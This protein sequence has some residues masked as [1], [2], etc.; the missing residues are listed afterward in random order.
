MV[1]LNS[2]NSY[3]GAIC[4]CSDSDDDGRVVRAKLLVSRLNP[5]RKVQW[6]GKGKYGESKSKEVLYSITSYSYSYSRKSE[7]KV[8]KAHGKI[9]LNRV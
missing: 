4:Y 2:Q 8:E 9:L 1:S 5:P 7:M 6:S 3:F